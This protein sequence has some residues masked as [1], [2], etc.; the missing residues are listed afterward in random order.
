MKINKH[1]LLPS[2]FL[3]I[4]LMPLTILLS[5]ILG[6]SM[7]TATFSATP[8]PQQDL[9]TTAQAVSSTTRT[10]LPTLTP[11]QVQKLNE[12][13]TATVRYFTS[14]EVNNIEIGF[15]HAFFGTGK[16]HEDWDGDGVWQEH[17]MTRGYGSHVNI[18]EVTLR[19]LS[20]AVAY[21]ME[22]LD[23]LPAGDRYAE[24]WGQV[25]TGLR[26]L[27]AMQT[28]GKPDQFF[29][30][31]FYRSYRTTSYSG[32]RDLYIGEIVKDEDK[33]SSDDN[34]L[35][36][37]NLLVLE[38]LAEDPTV[39]IPDRAEVL[40][41]CREIRGAIDLESFV[42]DNA[43]VHYYEDGGPS[44]T[45]WDRESAE[46]SVILA[47]ILLSDQITKDQFYRI[48]S[49]LENHPVNWSTLTGGAI[50]IDKPSYHSAMFIHGLRAIHGMPI[51]DEEFPGLNYFETSTK[52]VFEAH[53]DYTKHYGYEA[54]GTQV[55]TQ[56]LLG[57][58]LFVMNGKQVQF[59]GNEDNVMP[60]P[61]R[62]LS[63]ATGPH[64]W[65]IPLQRWRYLD[66]ED[67]DT[68]FDWIADYEAEFYHSG[69]DTLLGWE[70]TVP[71]TPTDQT[72]GWESS[73]G[74]W[75]YT[76]W[77]RPY[78]ALNAA[79]IILSIFDALNPDRPLASY[80]AKAGRLKHIAA[81]FDNG[82]LIPDD[83]P[84]ASQCVSDAN[85]N[86]IGDVED[87]MTTVSKRGCLSH[88]H[89]ALE[90][91]RQSWPT[92]GI[93]PAWCGSQ[94][95]FVS[96]RDGNREIY[97]M[98][99]DFSSQTRLTYNA[100][101]DF[102][103]TWSPD[104]QKIAF[105]S[106]RDEVYEIYVMNADGS[107]Q[108][109][110]T[111]SIS[112]CDTDLPIPPTWSSPAW[113]PDGN[114][115]VFAGGEGHASGD[116]CRGNIYKVHPDGTGLERKTSD[117]WGNSNDI[118]PAWSPILD[119]IVFSSNRTAK[120]CLTKMDAELGQG[121]GYGNMVTCPPTYPGSYSQP[122][123]S[124]DGQR[125]A[126][127]YLDEGNIYL[128]DKGGSNQIFLTNGYHPAWSP[129]GQYIVHDDEGTLHR[130]AI[131]P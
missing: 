1:Q 8:L 72:Y 95:A 108:G 11:L 128:I 48:A 116:P 87:I 86:G 39:D 20:L 78:E 25:L 4:F 76:D 84:P 115:I 17:D 120:Y 40:N 74:I 69:S 34:A 114:W 124:P 99:D 37:M 104:C 47:T 51:T 13:A 45:V 53:L 113:S 46:G 88:L 90:K 71:W 33:Q 97:V 93:N 103:P 2:K 58:P 3:P 73:G 29:E 9:V 94:I 57:T 75:N 35:P 26:T 16:F 31:H 121:G 83:T 60:V 79:Y 12:Y 23:Y 96:E 66:Q 131:S 111:G 130:A 32:D 81:Y 77:G 125:L 21:K 100:S 15:T 55:M 36:F 5:C 59:P 28:S 105:V 10:Q 27:R 19:F 126:F 80:N 70:A 49:S 65:F 89:L 64:A 38:G 107:D 112:L 119:E 85:G 62:S 14:H 98:N 102:A 82:T 106:N 101:D 43:I 54:L 6:W 122:A 129:D 30:G 41:L 67:I 92:E 109:P 91:W 61:G 127:V 7:I 24:S 56:P 22:W 42:V 118:E 110:I 52:P 123:W 18:N 63:R 68:I 117:P 50:E 44:T